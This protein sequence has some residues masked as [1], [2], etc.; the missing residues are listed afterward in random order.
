MKVNLVN[1][2]K[3]AEETMSYLARV[4]SQD[5][6]TDTKLLR[7]CAKHGH[8]SVFEMADMTVEIHTSRAI[9]QQIIRHK[10]FNFQEFSQ[11]YA[12]VQDN[13]FEVYE[14][15]SQD[16]K[17]R[18]SSH[19]DLPDS[20]KNWFLDLQDTVNTF[21]Y[22]AYNEALDRGIAKE[23][24]RTLLTLGTCTKMYMK[25]SIRSWI[26][27]LQV[28]TH[29]ST[30]KEHRDVANAIL[31]IFKEQLPTCYDAIFKDK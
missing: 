29:E 26:H 10:S 27:Y 19:D 8:W 4:S 23:C 6:R 28:R 22:T 17:N 18:Q 12:S 2:T 30:Q 16:E 1:I 20:T 3:N 7:Y 9:A 13:N 31:D 5:Q 21:A 24:A 25:G 14:A 11:R 15:R